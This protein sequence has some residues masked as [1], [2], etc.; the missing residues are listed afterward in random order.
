MSLNEAGVVMTIPVKVLLIFALWTLFVLMIGVSFYRWWMILSKR[1]VPGSF[2]ADRVEGSDFYR[3]A[4]RAHLNCVENLAIYG[5]LVIAIVATGIKNPL[6]D[7]LAI[8][9]IFARILQS[10]VHLS[11][12]QTPT[13]ATFRFLF[14]FTQYLCMIWMGL[15]VFLKA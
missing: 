15:F 1:A 10:S 2:P 12:V 8:V 5:A 9:L 11:F 6:L 7:K 13:V 14:Y 3:R 4:M